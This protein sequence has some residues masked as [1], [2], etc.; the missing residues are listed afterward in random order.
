[1]K[2]ATRK[3]VKPGKRAFKTKL[4]RTKSVPEL[5]PG[6]VPAATQKISRRTTF[7]GLPIEPCASQKSD[8][9]ILISTRGICLQTDEP[10]EPFLKTTTAK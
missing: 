9:R 10:V 8:D 3:S 2:D 6:V 4:A 5:S 1:M 7:N